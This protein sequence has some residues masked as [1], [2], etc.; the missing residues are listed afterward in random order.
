MAELIAVGADPAARWRRTLAPRQIIRLGRSPR[1]GWAVPWDPAVSREHV[2]IAWDAGKLRVRRLETARNPVFFRGRPVDQFLA[3]P[4]DC[5]VIGE[6]SFRVAE[7]EVAVP[8]EATSPREEHTFRPG[9]LRRIRFRDADH[10]LEVLA[11]FPEVIYGSLSDEEFHIRLV[12]LLLAGIPH[13][14]AA[15]VVARETSGTT[16]VRVVQWDRR[17]ESIGRFEPSHRL[18]VESLARR[19]S[20]LHVW[21][22]QRLADP[23]FTV[24]DSLDWAFATPLP[25]EVCGGLALYVAGT[26]GGPQGAGMAPVRHA[27]DLKGDIRFAELV[28]E[29]VAALR[30]VRVLERQRTQLSHFLPP[31]VLDALARDPSEHA[32]APRET[33]VTVLFCDVRGFS[34]E[35]EH[36]RNNLTGLLQRVSE[37]LGVMTRRILEHGGVIGDFQGDAAMGFWG[38]PL[39]APEGAL[40]ACRAALEI[41]GEFQRA[42][43]EPAHPLA[44]FQAG[45]GVAHGRAVAGKIGTADHAKLTVFGPVV[46][47][48]SRLEEM[49]KQL[50]V[51]ILLDEPTADYVRRHVDPS[52][53]RTRRLGRVRPYGMETPLMVSELLPPADQDPVFSDRSLADYESAVDALLA[54][55]WSDA[56]E[57]L[58]R[59]PAR[60][61]AKDFLTIFIAQHNYEPPAGWDGVI[62]MPKK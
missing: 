13:A 59:V 27:A 31:M 45:I 30:Q 40:E 4:G 18:I 6:T 39:A 14:E 56:I 61:R 5:F 17:R 60:D 25:G 21:G 8:L 33:E 23:E 16:G 50:R 3:G 9:D 58:H 20:I 28:A 48:A 12:N 29:L 38:W 26:F 36:W 42:A 43:R 55:R 54:G 46:N 47:L 32:L 10:R 49:T 57:L 37:A 51:P 52:Q 1:N 22:E 2:E 62:P 35:A 15:A 24:S 19:E 44:D 41:R 11:R 34:R 7:D 53:A